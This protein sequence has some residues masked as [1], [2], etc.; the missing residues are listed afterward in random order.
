[1]AGKTFALGRGESWASRLHER[2]VL[3]VQRAVHRPAE[4]MND[5]RFVNDLGFVNDEEFKAHL[6][7][8]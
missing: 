2:A 4:A 5:L 3:A 7:A 8:F 6:S 1:M